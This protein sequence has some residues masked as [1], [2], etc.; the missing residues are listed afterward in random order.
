[1]VHD[2]NTPREELDMAGSHHLLK[3][4]LSCG[5]NQAV[6]RDLFVA[7]LPPQRPTNLVVSM[8]HVTG[9]LMDHLP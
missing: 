2:M 6:G 5:A 1:M 9:A 4:R 7:I 3:Q 8:P